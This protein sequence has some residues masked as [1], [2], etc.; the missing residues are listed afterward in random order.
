MLDFFCF[1]DAKLQSFSYSL[2]PQNEQ[3]LIP[4]RWR[5]LT[6]GLWLPWLGRT[7]SQLPGDDRFFPLNFTL[8][9]RLSHHQIFSF[10]QDIF[11]WT[12]FPNVTLT[13]GWPSPVLSESLMQHIYDALQDNNSFLWPLNLKWCLNVMVIKD[14]RKKQH[15]L[16]GDRLRW[17]F[18]YLHFSNPYPC[19]DAW[20]FPS[21]FNRNKHKKLWQMLQ[22]I[23][24]GKPGNFKRSW[25]FYTLKEC[26]IQLLV[27]WTNIK[28]PQRIL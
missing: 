14:F 6:G 2:Y 26:D 24:M 15:V 3:L 4:Q 7:M 20:L 11:L 8:I 16:P 28:T 27:L 10:V 9:R 1:V 18:C 5:E 13:A 21:Y 25:M 17:F 23:V 22:S 19:Q 12:R